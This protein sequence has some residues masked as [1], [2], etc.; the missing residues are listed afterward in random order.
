MLL[1]T[2]KVVACVADDDCNGSAGCN[3]ASGSACKVA[4]ADCGT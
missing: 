4:G 1:T 3:R 2:G